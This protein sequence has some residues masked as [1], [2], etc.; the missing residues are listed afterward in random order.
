[1]DKLRLLKGNVEVYGNKK[2][3]RPLFLENVKL[4]FRL[5]VIQM[6]TVI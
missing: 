5:S 2:K 6:H 3:T 4:S 1:M